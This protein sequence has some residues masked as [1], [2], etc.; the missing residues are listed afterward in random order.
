MFFS[1]LLENTFIYYIIFQKL[2]EFSSD[3]NIQVSIQSKAFRNLK[4]MLV[5]LVFW[6][7]II[8]WI[9]CILCSYSG[10]WIED[11]ELTF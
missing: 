10:N 4:L 7:R 8:L 11:S 1:V 5:S 9:K 6:I 3:V 2:V